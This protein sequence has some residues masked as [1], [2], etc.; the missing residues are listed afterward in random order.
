M[1]L[2]TIYSHTEICKLEV[3][4]VPFHGGSILYRKQGP[5]NVK[6]FIWHLLTPLCIFTI[7]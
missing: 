6:E 4:L 5:M 7:T 3:R 1:N 2:H